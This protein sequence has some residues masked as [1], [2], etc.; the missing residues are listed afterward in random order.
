[1]NDKPYKP[2]ATGR[3]MLILASTREDRLVYSPTLPVA[4]ARQVVRSLLGAGM[5]EEVAA[6]AD[7]AGLVWRA[8]D[9]GSRL[10]LRATD[11]GVNAITGAIG[12]R[13]LADEIEAGDAVEEMAGTRDDTTGL[14]GS[15]ETGS[16][17]AAQGSVEAKTVPVPLDNATDHE[18]VPDAPV[19]PHPASGRVTLRQ[20]AE[21]VLHAW[22]GAS[23]NGTPSLVV[24][25]G[26]IDI[27]RSVLTKRAPTPATG[28]SKPPREGTKQAQV[29]AMLRGPEGT[30]VAQIAAAMTWAPHTV[31]GFFAGLKKRHGITVTA[32]ERVRQVGPNREGA[33]G[34]YTIYRIAVTG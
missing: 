27:L 22:D 23:D 24:L 29:L 28:S 13:D 18:A 4:A 10:A 11:L 16:V 5:V 25:R 21:A 12:P 19:A 20:A 34:S 3:A 30:T 33:K 8:A 26:P 6:P 2:S 14:A 31:R 1:M 9:D 17:E 7:D 15:G 32:A